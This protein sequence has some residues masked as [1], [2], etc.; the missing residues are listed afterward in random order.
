MSRIR[1]QELPQKFSSKDAHDGRAVANFVL[2]V[3]ESEGRSIS[4]L[5]IQKIVFFCHV[6]S[7]IELQRPLI[8]HVFEAWEHGP[9]LQYLYREFKEFDDRPI[10]K[11]AHRLNPQTGSLEIVPHDFDEATEALLRRVVNFYSRMLPYNLVEISH[12]EGGPW[13][14]AWHHEGSTNPGMKIENDAISA[15]Y[16]RARPPFSLQ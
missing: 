9:V 11:R 10:R 7:L 12:I 5:S 8:R 14:C 3:C 1:E 2:D 6:W 16:S 13:Y 4:N 15:F